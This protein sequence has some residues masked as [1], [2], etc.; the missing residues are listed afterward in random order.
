MK[1]ATVMVAGTLL[2]GLASA[3][4]PLKQQSPES[5]TIVSGRAPVVKISR[6]AESD[7]RYDVGPLVSEPVK[8]EDGIIEYLYS[9]DA[10]TLSNAFNARFYFDPANGS[11]TI[12]NLAG[13]AAND[14]YQFVS[15]VIT[16]PFENGV[17]TIPCSGLGADQP[18]ATR[19]GVL[20]AYGMDM[21]LQVGKIEFNDD[22]MS[23]VTDPQP[24]LKLY[25]SEDYS[26]IKTDLPEGYSVAGV[27]D[28][29]DMFG[30]WACSGACQGGLNFKKIESGVI[31]DISETSL[32]FGNVFVSNSESRTLTIKSK[33]DQP[34]NFTASVDSPVF[35]VEPESGTVNASDKLSLKVTYSPIEPGQEAATLTIKTAESEKRVVLSGNALSREADF[36]S[37]ITEGDPSC[38]SWENTSE[39]GWYV[40]DGNI[41][42]ENTVN[43]DI[44]ILKAVFS[45]NKPKRI[46]YDIDLKRSYQDTLSMRIEGR[47]MFN[48]SHRLNHTVSYIVPG[49][50]RTVEWILR[51]GMYPEGQVKISNMRIEEAQSWDGLS[52]DASLSPLTAEGYMNVNGN[53]VATN[54]NA[55]MMI[56]INPKA[57]SSFSFDYDSGDSEITVEINE[58]AVG[59]IGKGEKG[60]FHYDMETTEPAFVNVKVTTP[61][62][63]LANS[64]LIG[65]M[66]LTEG[67]FK[68]APVVYNA[69][70]NSYKDEDGTYTETSG[71]V[72][73]YP[74]E[75]TLTSGGKA[76]FRYLLPTSDIYT[77][78]QVIEGKIE[79]NKIHIPT[80]KNLNLCTLAGYDDSSLE[81]FPVYYNN[82]FWLVAGKVNNEMK[83]TEILD[84][85]VLT[86]SEDGR[87][88]T[89][90]SD[91]GVWATWSCEDS[92]I[93]D[94]FR[95]DS[96]FVA[97]AEGA[98]ITSSVDAVDFDNL[99]AN[100]FEYSKTL[101]VLASGTD[102]EYSAVI[103]GGDGHFS[104]SPA[105]GTISSGATEHLT[106]TFSSETPGDFSAVLNI[107]SDGNDIT[108]PLSAAVDRIP[109][110]SVIVS[111]GKELI[112]FDCNT[113]YPWNVEDGMA[114]STNEDINNTIS[115][116]ILDFTVPADKVGVFG[117]EGSTCAEPNYDGFAMRVNGKTIYSETVHNEN[118]KLSIPFTEGEY[119]I[120]L[121][122]VHDNVNEI[123]RAYDRS[124]ISDLSLRME[125]PGIHYLSLATPYRIEAPVGEV[126]SDVVE[127]KNYSDSPVEITGVE[128][129]GIFGAI[130]PSA[131]LVPKNGGSIEIPVT[132]R[133]D[134]AGDYSGHITVMSTAGKLEIPVS[135]SADYVKYIGVA[136]TSSFAAP[137]PTPLLI[138]GEV[139][140]TSTMMYPADAMKALK[141]ADIESLTFFTSSIPDYPF[142][143]QDVLAEVGETDSELVS[144]RIDGLTEVLTGE[145]PDVEY[146]E[147][148]ITF[149]SPYT[150]KGG[151]FIF[152]LR[153]NSNESF[154]GYNNVKIGF[155]SDTSLRGMTVVSLPDYT[156]EPQN[157]VPYMRVKYNPETVGVAP[158]AGTLSEI[159]EIRYYSLKGMRLS[160]PCEGLNIIVTVYEN[161]VSESSIMMKRK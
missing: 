122:H 104:V 8:A 74:V 43:E 154:D 99:I 94:F 79:G 32:D 88:I 65:N 14:D 5:R 62:D 35:K 142:T 22:F 115:S 126:V 19:L 86:I 12:E 108:I 71:K 134:K 156:D 150:Y 97:A 119:H 50:K 160:S 9:C 146:G 112:S 155:M 31:W 16:A 27:I 120:E 39:Q 140:V 96:R 58:T 106:V 64:A 67:K 47:P 103:E 159:R 7:S 81:S 72:H 56:S 21:Y 130:M 48:Y 90:D 149:D 36:S 30:F 38:V 1:I 63:K 2:A 28:Y 78:A 135:A 6:I 105:S 100:G 57:E 55:F 60:T 93:I 138:Y 161:G 98:E 110:Y 148:L 23:Y 128:G 10:T 20:E 87:T 49:G 15:D 80:Y 40:E 133:V 29:T 92:G 123:Y 24:E 61:S 102:C 158:V 42:C 107:Y 4:Y 132:F 73:A 152:Q 53:A 26:T 68:D 44:S 136:E 147:L 89:P 117:L 59:T 129:D 51:D 3:A 11:V 121:M 69:L 33:G 84:E 66:R 151:N 131:T 111:E 113:E 91:F 141:D 114:V 83:Q 76:L 118:M 124:M 54:S 85:L 77:D 139:D 45:G 17:I 41:I 101:S 144:G 52:P 116:L 153:N 109:D 143:C 18:G 46:T 82:R 13:F 75:I 34:V 127:I 95:A 25:V 125:N 157:T 70:V 37:V 137:Y 145:M